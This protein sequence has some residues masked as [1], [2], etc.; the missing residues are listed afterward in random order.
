M[1]T[2]RLDNTFY[3]KLV[4]NNYFSSLYRVNTRKAL[5]I[6]TCDSFMCSLVQL[7]G[8]ATLRVICG[9]K[10]KDKTAA[11]SHTKLQVTPQ[12]NY[13]NWRKTDLLRFCSIFLVTAL[14]SWCTSIF[15]DGAGRKAT[16]T[17]KIVLRLKK[18]YARSV[19]RYST[20]S[21]YL[22]YTLPL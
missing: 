8:N 11:L 22:R 5:S 9:S 10:L 16:D 21:V 19:T 20:F 4:P 15:R 3:P 18:G 13:S 1:K 2:K 6:P 17:E 7:G 12:P 14:T